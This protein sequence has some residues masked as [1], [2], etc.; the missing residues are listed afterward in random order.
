MRSTRSGIHLGTPFSRS[1][2]ATP[3]G[4]AWAPPAAATP[5]SSR[6]PTASIPV[7]STTSTSAAA[8]V[9][10][11]ASVPRCPVPRR[12]VRAV[13]RVPGRAPSKEYAPQGLS[14]SAEPRSGCLGGGVAAFEKARDH[15]D[16]DRVHG[17]RREGQ[18]RCGRGPSRSPC[19]GGLYV[20]RQGVTV[21]RGWQLLSTSAT[22]SARRGPPY[23]APL[24]AIGREGGGAPWGSEGQRKALATS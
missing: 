8:A 1:W 6:T 14:G 15:G 18:P 9:S 3:A 20:L 24:G 7:A 13:G 2:T 5:T 4:N 23:Q 19:W 16:D 21:C 17:E 12:S 22:N 10:T 11:T